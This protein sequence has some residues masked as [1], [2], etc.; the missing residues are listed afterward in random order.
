MRR[1]LIIAHGLVAGDG[2]ESVLGSSLR[3]IRTMSDEGEVERLAKLPEVAA[4]EALYLG[5]PPQEADIAQ[6]PLTVSALGADPPDRSTHFH[7]SLLSLQDGKIE[8]PRFVP[9]PEDEE[10][11]WQVARRLD[12]R[13]L[14]LLRGERLDHALVWEGL[15]DHRT[16]R[17]DQADGQPMQEHLPEGDAE[18]ALRRMVDDSV[19]LLA[20]LE[21]NAR[22]IDEGLQPLNVLWP[23]GEGVRP[24]VPN[25]LLRRGER[26]TVESAS[27]RMQGLARL[28][29]YAHEDRALMGRGL[30]TP[31][32]EV[33]KRALA[34]ELTVIYLHGPGELRRRGKLEELEWYARQMDERLLQPLVEEA[35]R[36]DSRVAL[37]ATGSGD[38]LFVQLRQHAVG[39]S[40]TPFEERV[41]EDLSVPRRDPWT[42]IDEVLT[43]ETIA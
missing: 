23:W 10:A 26:A 8:L 20:E 16:S 29:G 15:G 25:L 36:A 1:T 28:A 30:G 42:V 4:P 38:G 9:T 41:L 21:L 17:P 14:T 40:G 32:E 11:L 6:G 33:A 43:D 31:F 13:T 24:R 27:L 3:A 22:R 12:T 7:L 2:E 34:R 19:N 35:L 5:L 37:V 18:R 39:K